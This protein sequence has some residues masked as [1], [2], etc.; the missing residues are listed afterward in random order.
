MCPSNPGD[1]IAG[2]SGSHPRGLEWAD[3]IDKTPSA[4]ELRFTLAFIDLLRLC[5]CVRWRAQRQRPGCRWLTWRR[6]RRRQRQQWGPWA[7][8]HQRARCRVGS[9]QT[10]RPSLEVGNPSCDLAVQFSRL[11]TG[12]HMMNSS[13]RQRPAASELAQCCPLQLQLI[14]RVQEPPLASTSCTDMFRSAT[15]MSACSDRIKAGEMEM[16]L[17]IHG[18]PGAETLPVKP[19]DEIVAQVPQP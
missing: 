15:N 1:L 6:R 12:V 13:A 14:R 2:G 19:V 8:P 5:M 9:R 18:E 7:L 11:C 16:G 3:V 17:G 4:R 10:G